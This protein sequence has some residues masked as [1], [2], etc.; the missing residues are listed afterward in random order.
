MIDSERTLVKEQLSAGREA[1]LAAVEGLSDAQAV[2]KP[3]PE[4]WSI[5]EC[6]E[7][8]AVAER[9]MLRMIE[10]AGEGGRPSAPNKDLAFAASARD[11]SR[12]FVAPDPAKPRLRYGTLEEARRK[13]IE[14]RERTVAFVERC[15]ENL[16]TRSVLH[17]IAGQIDA[18]RC[19]LLIAAHPSRHA[20]QILEVRAHA[21]FPNP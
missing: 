17:P 18:Y 4:A 2:F 21:A 9:Q 15:S 1:M 11:R 8:V 19:L 20:A 14:N 16:R 6:L 12:K 5:L 3:S 7:H 13:F 10:G